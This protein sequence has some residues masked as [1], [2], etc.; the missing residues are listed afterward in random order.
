ML[1]PV[2]ILRLLKQIKVSQQEER[3]RAELVHDNDLG[4]LDGGGLEDKFDLG[5]KEGGGEIQSQMFMKLEVSKC[6]YP[7]Y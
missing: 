4:A 3:Q 5:E 1:E 2:C 6:C 7:H